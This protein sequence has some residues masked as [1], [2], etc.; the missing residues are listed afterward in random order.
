MI[1]DNTDGIASRP[2]PGIATD[3]R[4]TEPCAAPAPAL[5][6]SLMEELEAARQQGALSDASESAFAERLEDLW[7]DLTDDE[8]DAWNAQANT[9][10]ER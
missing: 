2:G 5:Y 7:W 10:S 8:Q 6:A 9:V 4:D 3:E 1:D